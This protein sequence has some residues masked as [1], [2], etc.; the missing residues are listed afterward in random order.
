MKS[1]RHSTEAAFTLIEMLLV[2]SLLSIITL[3]AV[4]ELDNLLPR[5]RLRASS[6][7]LA[8]T[9][10]S[11]RDQAILT[12]RK[13]GVRFDLDRGEYWIVLPSRE[14]LG[15]TYPD[16]FLGGFE[17]AGTEALSKHRLRTGVKFSGAQ[18]AGGPL[19]IA[20]TVALD[21]SPLGSFS[22]L[23]IHLENEQ[24]TEVT[25]RVNGMTGLPEF[26]DE[27]LTYESLNPAFIPR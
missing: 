23:V 10:Q 22:D 5:T 15:E 25:L 11:A 27:Y 24:D 1:V 16:S 9:I 8:S 20:G 17:G 26:Y 13:C 19:T 2:L 12:S 3:I 7:E 21:I 6:R 18:P 4:R 14:A